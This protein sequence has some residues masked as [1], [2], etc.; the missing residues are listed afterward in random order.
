MNCSGKGCHWTSD[1][2]PDCKQP[3]KV[4]KPAARFAPAELRHYPVVVV[5]H[6]FI[7][8]PGDTMRAMWCATG[9]TVSVRSLWSTSGRTKPQRLTSCCRKQRRSEKLIET[10]PDTKEH[11]DALLRF[12]EDYSYAPRNKLYRPGLEIDPDELTKA[13]GWFKS[14]AA[15]RLAQSPRPPYQ[16]LA[17]CSFLPRR[18]LLV[19]LALP[20]AEHSRISLGMKNSV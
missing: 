20:P 9:S 10:H 8:A 6:R 7:W 4:D 1:H 19:V 14:G 11:L 2:D 16:V 5:T 17:G 12:M 18:W 13:L 15:D 3:E